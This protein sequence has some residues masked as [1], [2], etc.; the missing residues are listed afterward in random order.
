VPTT[1]G[2][3]QQRMMGG[4]ILVDPVR[5]ATVAAGMIQ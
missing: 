3:A 4:F 1:E 5:G 2:Y